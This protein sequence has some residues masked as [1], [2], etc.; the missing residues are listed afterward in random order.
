MG[1]SKFSN[2]FTNKILSNFPF[3]YYKLLYKNIIIIII[4]LIVF[5]ILK[6]KN[7][8]LNKLDFLFTK[9]HK[10]LKYLIKKNNKID[11]IKY[12]IFDNIDFNEDL[13]CVDCLYAS[14]FSS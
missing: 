13:F 7:K 9:N 2:L 3:F 1:F 8:I 6:Y 4:L 11:N 5:I 12:T 10:I 14:S